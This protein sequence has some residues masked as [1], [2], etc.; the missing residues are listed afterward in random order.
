MKWIRGQKVVFDLPKPD[1][2]VWTSCTNQEVVLEG[3][4]VKEIADRISIT[5]RELSAVGL[6]LVTIV[7]PITQQPVTLSVYG[8][9]VA[10][11]RAIGVWVKQDMVAKG[12]PV[13]WDE[14]G[15]LIR[16]E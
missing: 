2:R 8:L 1:A 10:I 16:S 14:Q 3:A 15:R 5:T 12:E 7:D 13:N 11:T 6:E 9:S 4:T